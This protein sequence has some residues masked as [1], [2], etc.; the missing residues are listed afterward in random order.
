MNK[1]TNKNIIVLIT[2][3]SG[4]IGSAIAEDFAKNNSESVILA[5]FTACSK[6]SIDCSAKPIGTKIGP[7]EV[8]IFC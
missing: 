6:A 7:G 5:I 1:K 2:G 4:H 8:V 3:A